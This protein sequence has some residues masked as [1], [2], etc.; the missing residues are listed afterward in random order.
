[1]NIAER[2]DDFAEGIAVVRLQERFIAHRVAVTAEDMRHLLEDEDETDAG[3]QPFQHT[4]RKNSASTP[5]RNTPSPIWIRP[6]STRASRKASKL[7][8]IAR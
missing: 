4:A 8:S 5:V 7:P 3:Q 6:A 2:A 1:M